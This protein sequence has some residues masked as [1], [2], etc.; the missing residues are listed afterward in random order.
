MPSPPQCGG[1]RASWADHYEH[2]RRRGLEPGARGLGGDAEGLVLFLRLGTVSWT[3]GFATRTDAKLASPAPP[4][5]QG[6]LVRHD[7]FDVT[8][9]LAT[10]VGAAA[11]RE[12]A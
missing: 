6:V 1:S 11:A 10:M 8:Q 4:P 9:L 5:T 12:Q 2:L 3:E 7:R